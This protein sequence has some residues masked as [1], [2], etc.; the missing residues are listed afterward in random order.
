MQKL[1]E[2]FNGYYE[3][4]Y[5]APRLEEKFEG[6]VGRFDNLMNSDIGFKGLTWVFVDE[7]GDFLTSDREI[8]AYMLAVEDYIE[9]PLKTA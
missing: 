4:L 9:E 3:E 8:I 7:R 5:N 6:L 2:A 1:I